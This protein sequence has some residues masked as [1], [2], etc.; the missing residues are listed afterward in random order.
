MTLADKN[1]PAVLAFLLKNY[2]KESR[3]RMKWINDHQEQIRKAATFSGEVKNYTPDEVNKSLMVAGM[4]TTPRD[5]VVAAR[6]RFQ[7]PVK[8]FMQAQVGT[9]KPLEPTMFPVKNEAKVLL[10]ES[11]KDYLKARNKLGPEDKFNFIES[12]NWKY[13]WK[14][15]DSELKMRGPVHGRECH[16]KHMME[17]R[18]GPQPDPDY[19]VSPD[20]YSMFCDS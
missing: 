19:Y 4:A 3:L 1:N 9:T 12:G 11:S 10:S 2:E 5:H 16:M 15:G 17:N 6:H 7:A 8:D 18:V 20:N 13:G 14:L